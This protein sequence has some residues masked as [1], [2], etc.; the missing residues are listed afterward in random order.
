MHGTQR[1]IMG[2]SVTCHHWW[3]S[4]INIYDALN[5]PH[6]EHCDSNHPSFLISPSRSILIS[7][8]SAWWSHAVCWTSPCSRRQRESEAEEQNTADTKLNQR[9]NI[10]HPTTKVERNWCLLLK[11]K[12]G[13]DSVGILNMNKR[14]PANNKKNIQPV[15]QS[16][17]ESHGSRRSRCKTMTKVPG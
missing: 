6:T 13:G 5:Q 12:N 9:W 4:T 11:W 15:K 2:L 7:I 1:V 16:R 10:C 8:S 14:T 3:A 17:G